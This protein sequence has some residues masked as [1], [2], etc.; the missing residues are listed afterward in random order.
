[1][2]M[3]TMSSDPVVVH[4][5][6]PTRESSRKRTPKSMGPDFIEEYTTKSQKAARQ[7]ALASKIPLPGPLPSIPLPPLPP[8]VTTSSAGKSKLNS[9]LERSLS[10]GGRKL[11][12]EEDLSRV[13]IG[14]KLIINKASLLATAIPTEKEKP[15]CRVCT[16]KNAI[17]DASADQEGMIRC[18]TSG[19]KYA[20]HRSCSPYQPQLV[21]DGSRFRCMECRKCELCRKGKIYAIVDLMCTECNEVYHKTCYIDRGISYPTNPY[22]L[23]AENREFWKCGCCQVPRLETRPLK[24]RPREILPTPAT[25]APS[26]VA[27]QTVVTLNGIPATVAG[28]GSVLIE[29]PKNTDRGDGGRHPL[30]LDTRR[31]PKSPK[32]LRSLK[33]PKGLKRKK[34][35]LNHDVDFSSPLPEP[36]MVP[37]AEGLIPLSDCLPESV[38]SKLASARIPVQGTELLTLSRKEERR[39]RTKQEED[40]ELRQDMA[41]WS[42]EQ[43]E[44][45][46]RDSCPELSQLIVQNDLLG[47]ALVI[48]SRQQFLDLFQLPLGKALNMHAAVCRCRRMYF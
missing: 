29:I 34:V 28:N 5:H 41:L 25:P 37:T 44:A 19:C 33:S 26:V 9:L 1:M 7:L 17:A 42:V 18:C 23:D 6:L 20:V 39:I 47:S 40:S 46:F 14:P 38:R 16:K 24:K 32:R 2:T 8:P 31:I 30:I 35:K 11:L 48:I 10:N 43:C 4:N 45:Y 3:E 27:P 36:V 22:K 15:S 13:P 21:G 12:E